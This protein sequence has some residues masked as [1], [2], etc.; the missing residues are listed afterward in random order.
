MT[1]L[2]CGACR[3]EFES[4]TLPV[5]VHEWRVDGENVFLVLCRTCEEELADKLR[6]VTAGRLAA[7][8]P[9]AE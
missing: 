4:F 5:F 2:K 7:L 1:G 3:N 8:A 6:T 9:G